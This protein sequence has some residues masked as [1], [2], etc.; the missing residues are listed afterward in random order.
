MTA[1]AALDP[2][3]ERHEV[4]AALTAARS[5]AGV[6][7]VILATAGIARWA[8]VERMVG[9]DA[10]PGTTLGSLAWFTGVWP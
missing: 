3:P 10:E 1:A 8:T 7:A 9:M 2:E 5:R 6:V 4:A